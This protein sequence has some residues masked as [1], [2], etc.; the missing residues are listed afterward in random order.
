MSQ[1]SCERV[2]SYQQ[3][4]QSNLVKAFLVLHV[5]VLTDFK[6]NIKKQPPK[7]LYKKA[8]LKNFKIFIGKH[9]CWSHFL[10]SCRL[11]DLQFY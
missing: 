5:E 1:P 7:V 9:L 11:T 4:R 2:T 3:R 10:K 8:V 6:H